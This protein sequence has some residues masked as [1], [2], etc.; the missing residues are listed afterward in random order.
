MFGR[1][2]NS[3]LGVLKDSVVDYD[4]FE[5]ADR[6]LKDLK[7]ERW[8]VNICRFLIKRTLSKKM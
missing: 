5:F 2:I 6:N 7:R 3:T 8:N 1:P 4:A